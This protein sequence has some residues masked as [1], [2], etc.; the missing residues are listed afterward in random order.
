VR[1]Q[2]LAGI[3]GL[4]LAIGALGLPTTASANPGDKGATVIT[5]RATLN[6]GY[7]C[8]GGCSGTFSGTAVGSPSGH[9][10]GFYSYKEPCPPIS[11]TAT[12]TLVI[13]SAS[14]NFHWTRVGLTAV[15]TL[16]D[17]G[18]KTDGAAVSVFVPSPLPPVSAN[19]PPKCTPKNV[20]QYAT[21]VS[22]GAFT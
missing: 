17:A 12:G 2:K 11:G 4:M 6:N 22:V 18:G 9:V 13:G 16:N 19:Q 20:P 3:A 14:E 5:G 15:I 7:P 1:I 10:N 21:V 8:S